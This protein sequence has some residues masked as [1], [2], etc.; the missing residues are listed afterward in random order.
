MLI[1]H[2]AADALAF[3]HQGERLVDVVERHGVGD[4]RVDLDLTLHVPIDDFRHVGAAARAAEGGAA[5]DPAGDEL[6]RPR[7][8]L[9]AGAGDADD[10]ALAPAAMA[11]F[12]RHRA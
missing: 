5:P 12:Q 10:D 2:D 11:A 7:R 1:D 9:L 8:D 6:K 4:H 3:V